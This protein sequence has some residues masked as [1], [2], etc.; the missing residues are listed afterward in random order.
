MTTGLELHAISKSFGSNRVLDDVT[1]RI[2]PGEFLSL[3]GPSGCGKSTLLRIIAGLEHQDRGSVQIG[4]RAV[5]HLGP[6]ARN[7]AMVF[8]SY[9]LYPHMSAGDNIALP[10]SVS[11]LSLAERLPLIKHLSP[12]RRRIARE[13]AADVRAVAKQLQI[14]P[15]LLRRPGQLSGGQRQRVAL[16]R[17]MVRRPTVFLMDEPLSN[18]DAQLRVH[19][20]DELADLHARLGATFVYVTHDQ[21]EAMTMSDRVAMLDGGRLA[22]VG[23]PS[24]L[25]AT[26]ATLTVAKFIGSPMIN[27]LP[28]RIGDRG[29]VMLHDRVLAVTTALKPGTNVSIGVRGEDLTLSRVSGVAGAGQTVRVRRVEHHGADRLVFADISSPGSCSII[30]RIPGSGSNLG[31]IAPG[32]LATLSLRSAGLHI[33]DSDG[34]RVA[35]SPV[36]GKVETVKALV[37]QV[38]L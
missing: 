21:I 10:L 33:F 15:L 9:A 28:G 29:Q 22:Q 3:V 18:L 1:L 20:R 2:E 6:R 24:E 16:A 26:P 17:A 12:R 11:R 35:T 36:A 37:A 34:T 27:V 19:M 31:E 25:Y 38:A 13:I 4:E 30:V 7:I 23:R 32:D 8:Q 5:D 14:E